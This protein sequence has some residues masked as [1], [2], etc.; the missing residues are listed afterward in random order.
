MSFFGKIIQDQLAFFNTWLG[1]LSPA[2]TKKFTAKRT[3]QAQKKNVWPANDP[4][5]DIWRTLQ[6]NYFPERLDL[7]KYNVNWSRRRQKRTLAS[8]NVKS[9]VV[10][11]A[12]EM[13][14]VQCHDYLE[15]LLY[16]E[17]CHAVLGDKVSK[18]GKKRRWHGPEFKALEAR[19]EKTQLLEQWIKEGGWM[20]AIRSH[21]SRSYHASKKAVL[22]Y[23]KVK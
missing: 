2:A 6:S 11:V 1:K 7:L 20:R 18:V 16:H 22:A 5:K 4:L 15:P 21:R 10:I 8:C 23:K 13:S 9:R 14:L 3:T 17:M 19:H 12:A